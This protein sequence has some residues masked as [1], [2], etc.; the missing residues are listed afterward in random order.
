MI[1]APGRTETDPFAAVYHKRDQ[2]LRAHIAPISSEPFA[3]QRLRQ[4]F[5][6]SH[7]YLFI[8]MSRIDCVFPLKQQTFAVLTTKLPQCLPGSFASVTVALFRLLKPH[9]KIFPI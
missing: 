9:L 2:A 3:N 4:S 6:K 7:H 5:D 8:Q 1:Q